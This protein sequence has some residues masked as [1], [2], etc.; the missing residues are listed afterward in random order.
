VIYNALDD[1]SEDSPQ[2]DLRSCDLVCVGRLVRE[3]GFDNAIRALKAILGDYPDAR[4]TIVG[5]GPE[6]S[7]LERLA[8][9][10]G[11][12]ASVSFTG[13]VAP[14]NVGVLLRQAF[15][16]LIP[17]RWREPFGLVALQ[18]A[19]AGRPVVASRVGGL[20]EIVLDGA[21][22][23]LVAPDDPHGLAQAVRALLAE[24]AKAARMG[25]AARRDKRSRFDYGRFVTAYEQLY[26]RLGER[27][28]TRGV[29]A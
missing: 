22:G 19:E 20:A 23:S 29:R 18:A 24:P 16:I 8:S 12:S 17:S 1:A 14:E 2:F 9:G 26:R 27:R 6:R 21:T 13:W 4:L 28:E 15:A 3:K 11:V 10:S 25:V 7:N 5:D